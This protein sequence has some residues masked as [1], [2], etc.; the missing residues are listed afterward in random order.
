MRCILD[1]SASLLLSVALFVPSASPFILQSSRA[2][3]ASSTLSSSSPASTDDVNTSNAPP[4]L[5]GTT[6]LVCGANGFVGS[7][8]VRNLLRMQDG[9][10]EVRAVV[11]DAGKLESFSRLSYEIGAEEGKGTISPVWVTRDVSFEGTEEMKGYGLGK[12][13]VLSGDLL[14]SAFV[15]DAVSGCDSVVYCAAP[16]S[17]PLASLAP[18]ALF[19]KLLGSRDTMVD[20]TVEAE[21]VQLVATSLSMELKRKNFLSEYQ[22]W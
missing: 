13:K 1:S 4:S 17:N 8:V 6:V 7:R 10:A 22:I 18:D 12:V 15:K 19:K 3:C 16:E 20:G 14:D 5:K 2:H 11:R 21:G 9:P